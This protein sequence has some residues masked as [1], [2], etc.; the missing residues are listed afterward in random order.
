MAAVGFDSVQRV[1]E[2]LID[3]GFDSVWWVF[4]KLIDT[5][6]KLI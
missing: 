1:F 2:K 4:E 5:E 6:H 3:V